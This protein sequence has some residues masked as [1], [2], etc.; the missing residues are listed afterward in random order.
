[1]HNPR[2]IAG[3]V[4]AVGALLGRVLRHP[5]LTI[6]TLVTHDPTLGAF[7][8]LPG[9][10]PIDAAI[11]CAWGRRDR[12]ATALDRGPT[13]RAH[14]EPWSR[15]GFQREELAMGDKSPK[16]HMSTKAR[17]LK[18]KR[19]DKHAKSAA[20]DHIEIIPPKGKR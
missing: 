3:E 5:P 9:V 14:T 11:A 16:S 6:S 2:S 15:P 1:V 19:A 20:K 10:V 17:S 7:S 8:A 4:V 18:E 13:T 12:R